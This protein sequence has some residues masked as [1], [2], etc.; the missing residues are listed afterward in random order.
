[1][2]CWMPGSGPTV[3]M[4]ML[5]PMLVT[6]IT[7]EFSASDCACSAPHS[8]TAKFASMKTHSRMR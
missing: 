7:A 5:T 8:T 1:M 4:K 2:C 6:T 3:N